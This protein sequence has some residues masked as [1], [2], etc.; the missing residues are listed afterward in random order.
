[1]D[2]IQAEDDLA[3]LYYSGEKALIMY[4][5]LF[6]SKLNNAFAIIKKAEGGH[7]RS[8]RAKL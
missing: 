7:G 4:W 1:M 3:N 6:E 8:D 2:V 5:K